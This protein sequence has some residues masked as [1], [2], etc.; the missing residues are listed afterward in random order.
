MTLHELANAAADK[1]RLSIKD[2]AAKNAYRLLAHAI[3]LHGQVK[4]PHNCLA[5]LAQVLKER[6]GLAVSTGSLRWYRCNLSKDMEMVDRMVSLPAAY[7]TLV[8]EA[9]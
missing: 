1:A 3:A 8:R 9:A 2:T 7:K 6:T 5:V 4:L